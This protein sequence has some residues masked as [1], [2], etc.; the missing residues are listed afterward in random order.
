[1]SQELTLSAAPGQTFTATLM[2][3]STRVAQNIA[4]TESVVPGFYTG[5]VPG[6]TP[7]GAYKVLFLVGS[8]VRG[9]GELQWSGTAEV[10]PGSGGSSG[11]P[12]ANAVP[13]SYAAGTAG[14][15]LGRINQAT[16]TGPVV[17]VPGVPA[18]TGVCRVYGNFET[19]DNKPAMNLEVKFVLV[20]AGLTA[21]ERL[22]VGRTAVAHT[23]HLGRLCDEQNTPYIEL[24]RN[25]LLNPAG[26]T[27]RVYCAD[28]GVNGQVITLDSGVADLAALLLA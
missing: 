28:L 6:G 12:L 24:Q 16:P 3:G 21:S 5:S 25:D 14:E 13:G 15:V 20:T 10:Q 19:L 11:D 22:I 27:Y 4:M 17:V 7:A 2:N 18:E 23:D 1:M 9:A 26:T 8:T